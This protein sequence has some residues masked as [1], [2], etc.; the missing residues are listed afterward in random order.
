MLPIFRALVK[1]P[2]NLIGLD[3]VRY[4]EHYSLGGYAYLSSLAIETVID[5]GAHSGEFC[6]M[7]TK[8]LPSSSIFCFEPLREEFRQLAYRMR[9]R[10][11]FNAFNY[12][13]GD[14]NGTVEMYRNEYSQSSS[15]LPMAALHKRAFPYTERETTETVELR[16]LDDVLAGTDLAPEILVKVDVQGYEDKVIAGAEVVLSRSKAMIVEVSFQKLYE[17]QALFDAVYEILKK[18]GF[19]YLGNLYQLFNPIDGGIL[20]ADSLFVKQ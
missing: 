17:G 11:R 2:L 10:P 15:L 20:Q 3:L 9:G 7:I 8:V 16:R 13:L 5:V 18:K 1:K 4:R 19:A 12:A 6:Q 14:R